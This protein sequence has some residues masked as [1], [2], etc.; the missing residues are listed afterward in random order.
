MPMDDALLVRAAE[1]PDERSALA[2]RRE[3]QERARAFFE[4]IVE[5]RGVLDGWVKRFV[6]E[7]EDEDEEEEDDDDN[8]GSGG[9]DSSG[10]EDPSF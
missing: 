8:D 2:R 4:R 10:G 3:E 6:D 1:G 5:N 9:G 7:D